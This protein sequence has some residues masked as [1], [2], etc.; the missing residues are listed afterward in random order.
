MRF[1]Y[2]ES[3]MGADTN[4]QTLVQRHTL[5]PDAEK[6]YNFEFTDDDHQHEAD[7][8]KLKEIGAKTPILPSQI[9]TDLSFKHKLVWSNMIGF[10]ILHLFALY[11]TVI[12]FQNVPSYKTTMYC[13]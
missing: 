2:I 1:L 9:G 8:Q 3:E 11:G 7:L 10:I 13:K 4:S 6:N 12:T 5:S